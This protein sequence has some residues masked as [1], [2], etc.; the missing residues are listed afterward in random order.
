MDNYVCSK[1]GDTKK[2]G[3]KNLGHNTYLPYFFVKLMMLYKVLVCLFLDEKNRG[4]RMVF[5]SFKVDKTNGNYQGKNANMSPFFTL[6]GI[7]SL[8]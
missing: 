8:I 3:T 7:K 5:F 4:R 6:S 2:L 1:T